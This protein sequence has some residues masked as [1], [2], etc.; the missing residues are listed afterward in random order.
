MTEAPSTFHYAALMRQIEER[1]LRFWDEAEQ[2]PEV[3]AEA[4]ER[5]DDRTDQ[6]C[7]CKDVAGASPQSS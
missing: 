3:A 6:S 4:V 7:T 5:V 2:T 1:L